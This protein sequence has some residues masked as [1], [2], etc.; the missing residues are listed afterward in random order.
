MVTSLSLGCAGQW[1]FACLN[2]QPLEDVA[3][4]ALI[5]DC[6]TGPGSPQMLRQLGLSRTTHP[7]GRRHAADL[8]GP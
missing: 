1:V 3:T 5:K 6:L 4:R 7:T 8:I 2:T